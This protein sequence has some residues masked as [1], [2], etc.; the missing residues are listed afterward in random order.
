VLP[1]S[2]SS[3]KSQQTFG[4]VSFSRP[5]SLLLDC[6]QTDLDVSGT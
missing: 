6:R 2:D 3:E 5:T 1:S 4:F